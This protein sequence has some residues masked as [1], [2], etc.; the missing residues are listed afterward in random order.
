MKLRNQFTV[1][2]VYLAVIVSTLALATLRSQ[3]RGAQTAPAAPAAPAASPQPSPTVKPRFSLSTSRTYGADEKARVYIAYQGVDTLDFRVYQVKDPFRFFRQLNSP[4]QMGEEDRN[5]VAEVAATVERKPSFLERLRSFKSSV[6]RGVKNYFRGQLRRESRAAFNDKFRSGER[7][8]LNEADYARVPLLNSDQVTLRG[9]WRQVLTATESE[10]DTRMVPL[11]KL[12]PGLYLVEALNGSLRAYTVMVVT[13]LTMINK[14]TRDGQMLVYAVDRKSGEPRADV[15][16]E[17]VKGKKVVATGKTDGNGVLGVSVRKGQPARREGGAAQLEGVDNSYLVLARRG[18]QF[19]VSEL[20]PYYFGVS[21]DEG[22]GVVS[23]GRA[24]SYIY[25]DRPV[26][27]PE[28]KVYFKGIVRRL[29]EFGYETPI[30]RAA[31][32]KI[33]DQNNNEI[34]NKELPLSPRG[35]FSGEVDLAAGASLGYYSIVASL[36]DVQ[37]RGSFEVAE[38]KK[39]EFKVKVTTPKNFVPDGEKAKFTVEAKYFFGAP[40]TNGDV[41]YYIYR[42]RYYHW[43]FRD[44]D[45]DVIGGG[46]GS[47]ENGDYGYGDDMVKEGDGRLDA[48][49]RLEV[50][51]DVPPLDESQPYDFTYRLE[52]QVTDPSRRVE[53]G[54][55][56]FVG[57]RGNVVV[58]AQPERYVYYQNDNARIKIKAADYEGRPVSSK[59]GLK[60]IEVKY[61]RVEERNGD[62]SYFTYKAVE[63]DLSSAEVTTNSQGEAT[64][65][66]RVP[67]IGSIRIKTTVDDKGKRIPSDA[68]YIYGAD[69]NDRWGDWA[70][71]DSSSIKLIPDKKSY[72]PNE[73]AHVLAMLPA[74]KAHLLVT[75]EMASVM[76]HRRV[77]A[78]SRAVMIDVKID[79][80]FVPNV[81]LS[82][83]YVKDG[84]MFSSSKSINV[85]ARSK[86]LNLEIIP[87]KK[88][89]KP[90]DPASYTVVARN[91]DGT[92]AAGVELSLG[93]VDEAIYSVKP[94]NAGDIRRAFY[95][96]RYNGVETHFSTA[97]NFTGYSDSK[98]MELAANK[99]SYQLADFKNEGQLVE[100]K[101][102][103]DFKDTAFWKPDVVTGADG[104]ATV[105][106]DLPENLTTWR[107]TARAVTSDLRVGSIVSRVLA[108]KDLILRL[109]IPRFMTEGDTV[110]VSGVVHNY[111]NSDKATQIKLEVAGANL[112]DAAQQTVTVSKDGEQRI[113]W[114]ITTSQLGEATLTATAKTNEESDGVELKL[115]V[116]PLGLKR[117][118]GA[119]AAMAEE[120]GERAFTLDLPANANSLKRTLRVEAAPSIAGAMFGALDYLTGY[121]YG[122]VEQTMSSFLPNVIVAQTL[123]DVKTASIK[124]SNDLNA[125]VQRGL[126]RLYGFQHDD[127]GWGWWKDDKTDPFMTAYV[128]DGLTL[129]RRAGYAVHGDAIDRGRESVK[130]LLDVGKLE[131]G[132]PIDPESRAYL[133]Y[134]LNVS[135][136]K[137]NPAEARYVNDLFAK[138]AE[139]QPYGR[140]LLALALKSRG[141]DNRARQVVSELE[142]EA[143]VT[144]FDAHWESVRRPML[145]FSEDDDLEA[146]ALAVKALARVNSQSGILAKAA[147]WLVANRRNGYYWEST[148]HTAFAIFALSDYLKASREL[149]ADY[150]VE[151]Y[152]N[153]KQVL[154]SRVTAAEAAA[155]KSMVVELKGDQIAPSNQARVVKRGPGVLYASA[156]LD[157]YTREEN[158]ASQSSNT[159]KLEREYLRLR[160]NDGG[161]APSWKVEPLSG[162]LRS[163]DLIVARLRLQGARAQ[164]LMVEDPIPA[165]CEQIERV[166]GIDL[167]YSDDR[168]SDWYSNREFRDQRTVIFVDYFDGDATFQ[169]AMRVLIPGEFKVAPARAELMYQPTVQANTANVKLNIL[170]KK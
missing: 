72:K 139:L 34:F 114:R 40:V 67:V 141:D 168:W 109:E 169:Y 59:V 118:T 8:P 15:Q 21:S 17:V 125:K 170:D 69:R 137:P 38:Y 140:A 29:G 32:V 135:G 93:V 96:T 36:N 133:V 74:D 151:I 50:T 89:Y 105:K 54:K 27:R 46:E 47:D 9:A 142:G 119:A 11:N 61:E 160:V 60:F 87:D 16:V 55:A 53:E 28:Q 106:F 161:G 42:S 4:H 138:R 132:K 153:G 95:G 145:D 73:T 154:A 103:K 18:D 166:S 152:L 101:V 41:K 3:V 31:S 56:S 104:K 81:Y 35:T 26:Y 143:R 48:Q 25:T 68:G 85:P 82:V 120:T 43:W 1:V 49:G 94:D 76:S 155:G 57:T 162:E 63:R 128:V 88:Q 52:A 30:A 39:P 147:R 10:Y 62:H 159:L 12:E 117:T 45:D 80:R 64:Y 148:K 98:Q 158:T 157:Y 75:T 146:T 14:T 84:E 116:V 51:F 90:R 111:L 6:Y 24:A 19:A 92:P 107:A 22:E 20:E 165:G 113:D 127:G 126:D 115:P 130:K 13:D 2:V 124:S 121:P 167:D 71:E 112:L 44:E 78:T 97:Y 134:A 150:A 5:D 129:A 108:R 70:Y 131:N 102:R 23:S 110:T 86:F 33:T 136:D 99:R 156:T 77:D 100:P 83:A 37:A 7:L 163:G 79:E 144:D 65:D 91:A 123:K 149:S 66:Y 122:C 164:Y 58:F